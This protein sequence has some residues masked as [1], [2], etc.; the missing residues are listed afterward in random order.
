MWTE[1]DRAEG[2]RSELWRRLIRSFLAER[3]PPFRFVPG[4]SRLTLVHL[5]VLRI[6]PNLTHELFV[7]AACVRSE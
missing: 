3:E 6:L 7:W 2:V 4:L 1:N 5:C